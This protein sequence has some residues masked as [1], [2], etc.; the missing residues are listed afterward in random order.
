MLRHRTWDIPRRI[1]RAM[2]RPRARV[3]VKACHASS[4]TFT[5]AELLLW[6]LTRYRHGFKGITTAP[7]GRQVEMLAWAEIHQA[8]RTSRVAYPEPHQRMLTVQHGLRYLQGIA[9]NEG[10][11]FQGY[12]APDNGVSIIVIDEAPGVEQ[13][14]YEAIEGIRAGGDVR[15]LALGNPTVPSGPFYDMFTGHRRSWQTFTIGAFDTPNLRG[16]TLDDVLAMPEDDGGPLDDNPWPF[17][18]TRRYVREKFDEWGPGHPMWESRVL[19]MF[20]QQATNAMFPLVW[21]EGARNREAPDHPQL[22]VEAGI[23]VAG[24][25]KDETVVAVR[26]GNAIVGMHATKE[27]DP[28]GSVVAFLTPFASRLRRVRVDV[29][30]IGWNFYLHLRD[31]GFNVYP[32]NFGGQSLVV[33]E[34]ENRK[35]LNLKAEL[36]WGF[37]LRLQ[38]GGVDNLTDEIAV[39]QL[40]GILYDYDERGRVRVEPKKQAEKRGIASPDRAEAI[41][42]AFCH[43]AVEVDE[44]VVVDDPVSI[45]PL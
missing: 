19:G 6:G 17:L 5:A 33:D 25:G 11:N 31:L 28:R 37:R 32:V 10:V 14:I 12:H 26:C 43:P 41:I 35:F 18:I 2:A 1:L 29:T 30:G 27:P 34:A 4:K 8:I 21:I 38:E 39:G 40:S 3:A 7:T 20:P 22:E 44:R 23:D 24:P 36:Y 16:L 45:S 13:A 42:L 9:T 15:V